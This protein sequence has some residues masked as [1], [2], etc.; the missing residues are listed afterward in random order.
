[1]GT[2]GTLLA[3]IG[4]ECL[5]V[6]IDEGRSSSGSVASRSSNTARQLARKTSIEGRSSRGRPLTKGASTSPSKE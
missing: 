2:R 4:Q 5:H 6:V 1:V 3:A